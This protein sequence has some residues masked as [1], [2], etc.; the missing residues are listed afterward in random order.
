MK[1]L[2]Y[3]MV[4][5][6]F[7]LAF[8]V[9]CDGELDIEPQ[10]AISDDTALG[11][12]SDVQAALTGAYDELGN[13]DLWAGDWLMHADLF[14]DDGELF[15]NGSFIGPRQIFTKTILTDNGEVEEIWL[16]AYE[17]INRANN[18]LSALDVVD[19][20]DRDRIEGEAKFI[21]GA[22]YF[23]LTLYFG[24]DFNDGD[25]NS[26]PSVPLILDPTRVIDENSA[27][28]RASVAS[29][30]QQVIADLQDA[31]SLLPTS[32]GFFATTYAA[33]AMLSRVYMQQRNYSAA[34]TAASTV[35]ESNAFTLTGTFI[36]AFNN[37]TNTSED[38]FAMQVTSSDGTN[39]L[40]TFYAPAENG[41]RGDIDITDFHLTLYE[42]GDDRL[43][44][45]YFDNAGSR[46]TGK[47]ANGIDA[48]VNSIRLAEMYLT[49]AEANLRAGTMVGDDPLNDINII[50]SRVALPA[51]MMVTVADVLNERKLE[52][53]FEGMSLWD[54]KRT[55][56][57]VGSLA[58]NA[59][60]LVFPIPQ[61]EIDANTSL[62]QNPGY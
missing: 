22:T 40:N 14:A 19:A 36:S 13:A 17:T 23:F 4:L 44:Q 12:S 49:R 55:E 31:E 11:T 38:I 45:F 61:R 30:Y 53:A 28:A 43:N 33:S 60:E 29:V 32:N 20:V 57:S 59:N 50:R 37:G 5:G 8:L 48:N 25:A 56:G 21:R 39:G 2:L 7:T 46:R 6:L 62:T 54:I 52:L 18:V 10:Q 15:W 27:V 35:I 26:N 9:A 3:K 51:L 47:Y 1:N 24:K 42:A 34:A 16:E 41:G 58:W